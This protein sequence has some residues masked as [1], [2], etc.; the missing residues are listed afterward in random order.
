MQISTPNGDRQV[1]APVSAVLNLRI[2]A[3]VIEPWRGRSPLSGDMKK[4]E[5]AV[6]AAAA[7]ADESPG[8]SRWPMLGAPP[9]GT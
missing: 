7:L 4:V 3:S 1:V 8:P 9:T 6:V 2:N 5:L